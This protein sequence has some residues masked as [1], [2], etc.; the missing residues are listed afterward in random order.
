[1]SRENQIDRAI[2]IALL[3][4]GDRA[5]MLSVIRSAL[6]VSFDLDV[7]E[8][9]LKARLNACEGREWLTATD[10]ELLGRVWKLTTDGRIKAQQ[11]G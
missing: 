6:R 10:V 8:A 4:A 2:L 5:L 9:D 7:T 11:I 1:M 3:A